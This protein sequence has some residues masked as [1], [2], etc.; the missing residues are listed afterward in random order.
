MT[1]GEFVVN[2]GKEGIWTQMDTHT[3]RTPRED[4][5]R[6]QAKGCRQTSRERHG[7]DSPL[8]PSE[9]NNP[10][11]THL[12]P[13]VHGTIHFCC[14]SPRKLTQRP[15]HHMGATA[16]SAVRAPAT[17]PPPHLQDQL[18][19]GEAVPVPEPPPPR[20]PSEPRSW[21]I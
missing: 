15:S 17:L 3:R 16:C 20:H 8:Q 4:E 13:L 21:D 5:G 10:A 14:L 12:R 19:L 18:P 1:V 6:E 2:W 7:T 9:G 11:N